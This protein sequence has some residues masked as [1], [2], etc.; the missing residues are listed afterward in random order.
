MG[1]YR[2]NRRRLPWR[3]QPTPYRVW[4]SEIMLQQRRVESAL[5]YF[6][7]FT[8]RWPTPEAL[9]AAPLAH[10]LEAWAGLGYYSRARKLHAAAGAIAAGGFPADV[11]GLRALPG[12]GDYT[13]GAIASIALGLDAPCVDGN[14]ERVL[15]RLAGIRED[16]RRAAGRRRV[17]GLAAD[18]LPRGRAGDWNQA[19]MD[20]GSRICTPRA[21]RCGECPLA[22][23]CA[24]RA[25]G[26]PEAIPLKKR[27]APSPQIRAACGAR[28]E[29]AG[30]LLSRR[31]EQGLLA[32]M[33][34]L[35]SEPVAPGEPEERALERA[36]ARL[37]LAIRAARRVGEV[38]H[39]FTHRRLRLGVWRV[40][41][42][43][44][45]GGE[46]PWREVPRA[47]L[48]ALGVS[49]LTRKSLD[50]AGLGVQTALFA[51]DPAAAWADQ[52]GSKG[53]S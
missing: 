17:W 30:V 48:A 5:P 35:P 49:T 21:P 32:G 41:A 38:E 7:R 34:E 50:A 3:E 47:A 6:Q 29:A 27:R 45:P 25:A 36:F 51:A 9:A 4:L 14:I 53:S 10:I 39:V 1:W 24:A 15:C 11:A 20:L 22:P 42:P 28:V 8:S 12:V 31:P 13:A 46:R 16:P 19:M 52:P 23:R 44:A 43:G 40:D 26:D 33:W 2:S 37:G 18:W